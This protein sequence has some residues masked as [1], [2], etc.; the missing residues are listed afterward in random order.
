MKP[1]DGYLTREQLTPQAEVL[2]TVRAVL[3][4]SRLLTTRLL[5]SEPAYHWVAV[6]VRLRSAPGV[7]QAALS[8]AVRRRLYCYLNP[9]TGGLDGKGWPFGR[10]LYASDVYQCLQGTPDV[11]FVRGLELYEADEN[12]Q[13]RGTAKE[14][15]EP[16]AHGVIVSGLHT[17][18]FV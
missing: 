17:V 16:L 10:S 8:A 5:V 11:L 1:P 15:I 7:N 9:L 3:D 18:E 12:G 2:N 13:P 6:V 14:E 4:E